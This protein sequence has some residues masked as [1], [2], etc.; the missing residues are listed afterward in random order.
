M[1]QAKL[2]GP[3]E[4]LEDDERHIGPNSTA[5]R[6]RLYP[7]NV[8]N[9]RLPG[10]DEGQSVMSLSSCAKSRLK[11]H[12]AAASFKRPGTVFYKK[13]LRG[14]SKE[15]LALTA[16]TQRPR[17]GHALNVQWPAQLKKPEHFLASLQNAATDQLSCR[18]THAQVQI[19]AANTSLHK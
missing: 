4:S 14:G 1:P 16:A 18:L 19:D 17:K 10:I 2:H 15:S 5:V 9:N 7:T 13:A 8:T 3:R 11:K 12:R 6:L